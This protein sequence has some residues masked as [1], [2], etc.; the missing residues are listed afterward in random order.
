MNVFVLC[1]G[2]CGSV[3][4]VKACS[5][6]VN[7]TSDHESRVHMVGP[8]RLAYPA[9]HIEADNRLSWFL[10]RLERSYGNS[11]FYVHLTRSRE[12]TARSFTKR[13]DQGIM[14]A[15]RDGVLIKLPAE[16]D[17]M[18]VSLDY[19]DTV[20]SNIDAF[21]RDK[22]H[23]MSFRLETAKTDFQHFWSRIDAKGN[24]TDALAEWDHV[25]NESRR[26]DSGRPRVLEQFSRAIRE[27]PSALRKR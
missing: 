20:D 9:N 14:Q 7:Y 8:E 22:T 3:T 24:L 2:R 4:F 19:C 17:R 25:Y 18:A 10:G 1:T 15:Y 16:S 6:I 23:K 5:H 11:A 13:W 27:L 21:L 12:D 26:P